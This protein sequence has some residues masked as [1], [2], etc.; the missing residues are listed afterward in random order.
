MISLNSMYMFTVDQFTFFSPIFFTPVAVDSSVLVME[1]VRH[2]EGKLSATKAWESTSGLSL[3]LRMEYHLQK[4]ASRDQDPFMEMCGALTR[5]RR[6][7][8]WSK[9]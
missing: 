1:S 7:S 2:T 9:T 3:I 8:P 5:L 6:S 4:P